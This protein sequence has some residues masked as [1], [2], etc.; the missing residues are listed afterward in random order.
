M[1]KWWVKLKSSSAGVGSIFPVWEGT[2]KPSSGR[3]ERTLSGIDSTERE[4]FS[5]NRKLC[6]QIEEGGFTCGVEKAE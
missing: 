4:V 5:G 6:Q 1:Q 2:G 3:Y